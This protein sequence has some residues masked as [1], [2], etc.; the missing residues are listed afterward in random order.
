MEKFSRNECSS[1]S[2]DADY[3]TL[4]NSSQN[5]L[6]HSVIYQ[7]AQELSAVPAQPLSGSQNISQLLTIRQL[8]N[9]IKKLQYEI[10]AEEPQPL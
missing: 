10:S 2:E 8:E 4:P 6:V 3:E 1:E 5:Q 7:P 9:N